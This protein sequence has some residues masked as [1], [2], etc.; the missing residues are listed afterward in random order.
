MVVTPDSKQ[1]KQTKQA[2]ADMM[3]AS[4]V[5]LVSVIVPNYNHAPYLQE[6]L[7]S[8]R[9]Q[10]FQDF[11]LIVLDDASTD[12]SVQI[13]KACL[14][15]YDYQLIQNEQNSGSTFKQWDKGIS[16]AKGKYIWMAESD[17]VAE[18]TLLEKLVSSMESTDSALA[19]C[20]SLGIDE[21]STVISEI[22]GW[23]D[24]YSRHL[25]S[26]NFSMDGNFFCIQY[27][28]IKCVIPNASAVLFR[29][30]CYISPVVAPPCLQLA[31]DWM[32]WIRILLQRRICFVAEPLNRFRFLPGSVRKTR[33]SIYFQECVRCTLY[34][35]DQTNAW[36]S[37]AEL[38]PLKR[39]LLALWLGIGLEPASPRNWVQRRDA[40]GVLWKLHGVR[41]A[42]M[43]L[44][45]WPASVVRC[46]LPIRMFLYLGCRS[47]PGKL[48]AMKHAGRGK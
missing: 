48:A 14:A 40:Y 26:N 12:D 23:T 18:P 44:L 36:Q 11:E 42:A 39:H 33:H 20:Q 13:I 16:F 30:D 17:D 37:P 6:R 1:M 8:I 28:A 10:T 25:W 31:G 45:A 27:M 34:I 24:G 22:K 32:L 21:N 29:R 3:A 5:P 41:L 9:N 46:T 47:I 19:Y 7:D 15:G 38:L 43:L 4:T 2:K 35:L